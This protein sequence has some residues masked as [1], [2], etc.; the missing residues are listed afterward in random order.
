MTP[1]HRPC[2][3]ASICTTLAAAA[4]LALTAG[5][6]PPDDYEACPVV[7]YGPAT[8]AAAPLHT[9]GQFFRD[10]AGRAV[11]LRGVNATG[12]A[13]VPPFQTVT[14]P[15]LLDP[16]PGWGLNAV[17]LLFT[18]E[19]F[20]P[21]R[22][23]YD[24]DY[25]AYYEQAVAWAAERN[26]YVI[27]DFH[28]DAYSRFNINGCGEGFP[29]WA[30]T[31]AITKATP[32]NSAACASWGSAMITD[33]DMHTTWNHFHSDREGARTRYLDMVKAVAERLSDHP[34]VIGYEI[35]NE[36]WGS[37][38][39]LNKLINDVGAA[40]R[41]RHPSAI[42][43]VPAHALVSGGVKTNT[44]AQPA[45]ANITYSSHYYDPSVYFKNWNGNPLD[46]ALDKALAKATGWN[47]PLIMSEFG[48]P[49]DT[50]NVA[51]YME[52]YYTWLDANFV[53]G[54]QWS[55]TPNWT[56]ERKDGW[57]AEDF[58]IVDD[59]GQLRPQLFEPRPYPQYTA[60]TP[61]S[62]S[63]TASGT[64]YRWHN[65]ADAG[66]TEIYLP[67]GYATGKTL[68]VSG[69]GTCTLQ[70][71]RIVCSGADGVIEVTLQ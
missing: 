19:A 50:V 2:N 28:Q 42:L 20:E 40:I 52:A 24:N 56:P 51:G 47:A 44:L 57:N 11:L 37:D 63:R 6:N 21:T 53:S 30:V 66:A 46:P 69:D 16:L 36:P 13:K 49:A 71:Q 3:P 67:A 48:A 15:L 58:S 17:R 12:D 14:S 9:D 60:G 10:S 55:Y 70:P 18:W 43:F 5:C 8:Q 38:A 31:S 4:L 26:I 34:N 27:V 23:S 25:L 45:H 7:N 62:F 65:L 33:L 32:D 64:T 68:S 39:Q 1:H 35:M 41:D 59:S 29:Q 54:T 22:C 61:Q